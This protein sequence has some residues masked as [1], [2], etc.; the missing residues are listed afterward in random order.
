M[1]PLTQAPEVENPNL[2]GNLRAASR[3]EVVETP[4]FHIN[5]M[6]R[7]NYE[8]KYTYKYTYAS[9]LYS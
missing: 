6:G 7:S 3:G 9:I 8:H 1:Q 2:N 4:S 5:H